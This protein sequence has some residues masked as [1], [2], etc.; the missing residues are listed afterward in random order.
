MTQ[1][2]CLL[3]TVLS[4][5][6]SSCKDEHKDLK[7]GLYA[8]I[9]TSKGTIIAELDYKKVPYMVANFVTLAEGKNQFCTEDLKGKPFFDGLE[10]HR[11]ISKSNGDA[12]D[13]M[14]QTGDPL[15][16]GSGDAGY[17][18]RDEITNLKHDKP[19][20]L[21]MANSGPNTNTNSSQFFITLVPTPWLDGKHSVFGCVVGDGMTVANSIVKGDVIKTV[22]IIR[23]GED[24]KK[25]DAVKIFNDNFKAQNE[26]Q[27]KQDALAEQKKM[28]YDAKYKAVKEKKI[29]YFNGLKKSATKT[30]SGLKFTITQKSSKEKPKDG[31]T[32]YIAYAGFLEDGTLFDTS[33]PNVAK[34]FGMYDEQRA[35]ENG[36]SALPYVMGSNK[37]IPGFVEGLSKLKIGDKAVFFIPSNLGYGEQ[38][39]GG[40][41]P[42]NANLI[43]ELEV[44]SKI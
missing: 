7:D 6:L 1:K 33:E 14:I 27:K 34:E 31:E 29:A 30:S 21:S 20:I 26:D 8:E 19:G 22:T 37:M 9:E 16:T 35:M 18:C 38:G 23:K 25:F 28:E 11:V 36:Y 40:V 44:K 10:F 3:L 15:G 42:P 39:A 32:I 43:F 13:F 12:E 2:I 41:I 24:V 5:C 4:I 17:K